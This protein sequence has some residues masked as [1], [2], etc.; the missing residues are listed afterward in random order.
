MLE[1]VGLQD[2]AWVTQLLP[3]T[4]LLERRALFEPSAKPYARLAT[5]SVRLRI[6]DLSQ[7]SAL[8]EP[9]DVLKSVVPAARRTRHAVY[10]ATHEGRQIYL[11][12]ALLFPE[13]WNWTDG[14]L[15]ALLTPNSLALCLSCGD[16]ADAPSVHVAG[17][18]ARTAASDTGLRRLCWLAQCSDAQA[19]WSSVLTFAHRG[20]LRLRLPRASLDVWARGVELPTGLLIGECWAVNLSFELPKSDYIVSVGGATRCCPPAPTRRTGFVSF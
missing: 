2:A 9:G 12:A 1:A 3:A 18:L 17:L 10:V 19:S 7:L 14:C 11:P 5:S 20:E 13:L 4:W 16:A 15:E 6:P 8:L